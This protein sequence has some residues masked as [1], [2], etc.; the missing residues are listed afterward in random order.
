MAGKPTY[1]ALLQQV[2]ELENS[3]AEKDRKEKAL[4][5]RILALTQPRDSAE[6]LELEDLFDMED[7]Q[8]LQDDFARA[9]GVASIITRIDGSPITQPSNFCRLCEKIIRKTE[10]G[11]ANCCKS[12]AALGKLS[13]DGPMIQP[14]MS[15]GLWDAGAGISVGGK[16]IANWLIGQVRDET[17]TEE[18]MR[19]YAREIGVDEATMIEAFREVP[20]MSLE[21]FRHIARMLFT[22][23]NQ[24]SAMAY[25]NVQQ[26]RFIADLKRS[27]EALKESEARLQTLI[28]TLPDLIWLKDPQ[29]V[30]LSCNPRFEAHFGA[31]EKD[32]VGKTDYDFLS[33]KRAESYRREDRQVLDE[34]RPIRN[35]SEFIFASDGHREILETIKTPMY[36]SDGRL[37]GVLGIGRDTTDRKKAEQK[38]Q[39]SRVRYQALYQ[40]SLKRTRLYE[41]LLES[42]PIALVIYNLDGQ[43]TYVNP[44]FTSTFGFTMQDVKGRRIPFVPEEEKEKS[45]AGI[46]QVLNGEPVF[47]LSTRRLTKDG[48]ILD[49]LLSSSC[50]DDDT[51][52]RAGIVVFLRDVTQVKQTEAQLLQAQKMESVGRLAGGVA[53]D[54]NNMLSVIL[55]YTELE[56]AQLDESQPLYN[57][58]K[59]IRRAATRSANLTRQLL[60]FARKQTVTPKVLD[61]NRTL[62]GMLKMLRR[63]LGEDIDLVWRPTENIWPVKLDASQVDQLLTN[64]CVNARDA[65]RDVGRIT[66]ETGKKILDEAYCSQNQGFVPGEY[67]MLTVSDDGC[68]MPRETRDKI[69]EPFF[70]TK[71]SRQGTGL[72]LST[73]YGIVKQNNGFINVYSEPGHG[74]TFR[75]YLPSYLGQAAENIKQDAQTV[76]HGNGEVVLIV[77]DEPLIL[78]LAERMLQNIG[79]TVLTADSPKKA[80][81]LAKTHIG[82]V[83]LV[84]TDVVMPELNGQ[85]LAAR[86]KD[87]YP[88]IKCLFMSGYTANVIAHHGVLDEGV[89]FIQKPFTTSELA[90]KVN[91]ALAIK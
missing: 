39:R 67:V 21:T 40:E 50:Y 12:D 2:R 44:A 36:R 33:K 24:L 28:R 17:Q 20:S 57:S 19:N 56:M 90:L 31:R 61:L 37:I 77:E 42:V 58:L 43:A 34:G 59:E 71:G 45:L 47:S 88:D 27:E 64:L 18:N 91:E 79:Y 3:L 52:N 70:T 14:C 41:S 54:F 83:T 15:D 22:L 76:P 72:G 82:D 9:T 53:H 23:A 49:I 8:R 26:V 69:F 11:F 48:R 5:R 87:L 55:G 60:A 10:Q 65:I 51:G 29:S 6:G 68:G 80:L 13:A 16:H 63:L 62:E 1:E 75:I 78:N 25:Q 32:I 74:T 84:V 89:N 81:Q 35:E 86:L 4:K 38:L 46:Q 7:I 73:V 85:E 66:I 30:Y